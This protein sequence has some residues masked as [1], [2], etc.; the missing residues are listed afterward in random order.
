MPIDAAANPERGNVAVF[1][2]GGAVKFRVLKSFALDWMRR[3][4]P[5]TLFQSHFDTCPNADRHRKKAR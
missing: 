1:I 5:H 4:Y 2:S 3:N